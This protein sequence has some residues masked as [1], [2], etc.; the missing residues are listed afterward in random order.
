MPKSDDFEAWIRFTVPWQ[1]GLTPSKQVAMR[2]KSYKFGTLARAL[3]KEA[4]QEY[5]R[6]LDALQDKM[7]EVY[8]WRAPKGKEISP[9]VT[10]TKEAAL[11]SRLLVEANWL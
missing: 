3:Q 8:K 4:P 11:A 5:K 9:I 7:E 10:K 2:I 1:L 6:F